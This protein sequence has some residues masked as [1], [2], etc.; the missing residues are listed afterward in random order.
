L[1]SE[2]I[3]KR[4]GIIDKFIGDAV[5]AFW[6]PPFVSPEEGAVHCCHA[7]LEQQQKIEILKN[8]LPEILGIRKGLPEISVRMGVATSECVA[9]NVG[10]AHSKSFTVIGPATEW[11]EILETLNKVY[12][13][14]IMIL[15]TTAALVGGQMELRRLDR[16]EIGSGNKMNVYELL[17]PA[18]AVPIETIEY[19]I[20]YENALDCR[21]SGDVENATNLFLACKAKNPEDGAVDVHLLAMGGS[22]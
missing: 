4:Q 8:M 12:K 16:V 9:G 17:G 19:K 10:S 3:V 14:E 15:E 18:G 2:P 6:P 20:E 11:A 5:V 7:A 22:K 21:D 1:V 13:T